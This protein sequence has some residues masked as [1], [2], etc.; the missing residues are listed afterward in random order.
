[1]AAAANI[2][3]T[4]GPLTFQWKRNG[5]V[6]PDATNATYITS[7]L[8]L[9]DNGTSFSCGLVSGTFTVESASAYV[10][11]INTA[12]RYPQ[13]V[14]ADNPLVYYRLEELGGSVAF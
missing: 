13:A 7:S 9:A 3:G 2:F 8:S 10:T 5:T 6:I 1:M 4:G 12:S 11:V 14:L